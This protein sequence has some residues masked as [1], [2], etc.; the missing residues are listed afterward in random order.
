MRN[1]LQLPTI[2]NVVA[3]AT[4]TLLMPTHAAYEMVKF[5]LT[6]V[7][8][9][10]MKNIKL[11]I[12]GITVQEYADGAELQAINGYKSYSADATGYLS[13]FFIQPELNDIPYFIMGPSGK[14]DVKSSD[15]EVTK[16]GTLD[17]QTLVIEFD[18]DSGVT[19]PAISASA[20]VSNNQL[21]GFIKKVRRHTKNASAS[22]IQEVDNIPTNGARISAIHFKKGDI[23][24]I[25]VRASNQTVYEAE[26][27]EA[28]Q[29]QKDFGRTPNTSYFHVDWTM[30]GDSDDALATAGLS[31]FRCKLDHAATGAYS[32]TVEYIDTLNGGV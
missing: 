9:A 28:R 15:R 18:L 6:N 30:T 10:Q 14:K 22:G 2:S 32:Y 31:D 27:V 16:L 3:G 13:W 21:L 8:P 17:V 25:E 24:K 12:N 4:A 1:T 19:N 11:K 29:Y 5:K 26:K 7:T 20:I 23:N